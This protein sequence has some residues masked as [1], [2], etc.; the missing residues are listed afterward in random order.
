MLLKQQDLKLSP[1]QLK[2]QVHSTYTIC[3]D[4]TAVVNTANCN[5]ATRILNLVKID[6]YVEA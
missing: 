3:T 6:R 5:R 1:L 2:L 4:T